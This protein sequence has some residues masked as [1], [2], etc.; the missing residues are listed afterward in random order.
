MVQKIYFCKMLNYL[1]MG[2]FIGEL[3]GNKI[4]VIYECKLMVDVRICSVL[5]RD[6]FATFYFFL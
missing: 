6:Y 3:D 2:W 1:R 5:E 4:V